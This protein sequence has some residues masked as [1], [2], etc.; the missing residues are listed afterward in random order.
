LMRALAV[1]MRP[2]QG[3]GQEDEWREGRS[4]MGD[5]LCGYSVSG[6]SASGVRSGC[7][8]LLAVCVTALPRYLPRPW[9]VDEALGSLGLSL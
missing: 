8:W 6:L 5:W 7:Q 1:V 3:E 2:R 9:T 4:E